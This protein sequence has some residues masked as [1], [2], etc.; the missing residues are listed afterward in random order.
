MLVILA[1]DQFLSPQQICP[2]CLLADRSGQPRWQNGQLKC[3]GV[4]VP[5]AANQAPQFECPMGFRIVQIDG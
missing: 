5:A 4:A 2:Q 1:G 3:G